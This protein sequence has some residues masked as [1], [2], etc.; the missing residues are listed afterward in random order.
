MKIVRGM[1]ST[2]SK[3]DNQHHLNG[4]VCIVEDDNSDV[5]RVHFTSGVVHN[6]RIQRHKLVFFTI[7]GDSK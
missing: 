1:I 4:T 3:D 6:M 2:Q 5:V 7:L